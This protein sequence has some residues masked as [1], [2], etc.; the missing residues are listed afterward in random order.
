[1]LKSEMLE[2][3]KNAK[4]GN[5]TINLSWTDMV[6]GK[7]LTHSIDV[8]IMRPADWKSAFLSGE[9]SKGGN[10]EISK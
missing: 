4:V 2:E 3:G 10:Q 9:I 7:E 5:S 8:E 1:M 6:T